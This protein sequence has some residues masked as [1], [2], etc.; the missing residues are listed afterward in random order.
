MTAA[1]FAAGYAAKAFKSHFDLQHA[2]Q[3][4]LNEA[5]QAEQRRLNELNQA[6]QRR[7]NELNQAE[8]RRCNE[9][10]QAEQR[11]MIAEERARYEQRLFDA[12]FHAEHQEWRIARTA[13]A[14]SKAD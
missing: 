2:E 13:P 6:E 14:R 11:S 4:R 1:A 8:Q 10:N 3:C 7:L 9:V 12:A 5:K